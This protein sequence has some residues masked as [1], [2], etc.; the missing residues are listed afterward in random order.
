ME[1]ESLGGLIDLAPGEEVEH[2][3]VW[4]FYE[5]IEEPD[6]EAMALGIAARL[7]LWAA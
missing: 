3:E 5:G 6:D 2:E 4:R 7:G 1:V